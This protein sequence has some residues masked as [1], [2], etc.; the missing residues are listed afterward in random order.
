MSF[1]RTILSS[2]LFF[3]VN[4]FAGEEMSTLQ[5]FD[6]DVV[7]TRIE[8]RKF[9]KITQNLSSNNSMTAKERAQAAK[10]ADKHIAVA[11]KNWGAV[12][13]KYQ[14]SIPEQY[15]NDSMFVQKLGNIE[16]MISQMRQHAAEAHFESALKTSADACD[17]FVQ[18]HEENGLHYAID[19][20]FYLRNAVKGLMVKADSVSI[21][22]MAVLIRPLIDIRNNMTTVACPYPT[23]KEKCLCYSARIDKLSKSMDDIA[24]AITV[25]NVKNMKESIHQ[26]PSI[27]DEAYDAALNCTGYKSM[28]DDNAAS[29]IKG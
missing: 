20:L 2:A 8:M 4:A 22:S 19:K 17:Q 26:L 7:K 9:C 25:R 21:D 23:S 27:L 15:R 10:L 5:Q 29:D 13:G 18:M 6:F 28:Q 11:L 24:L 1:T 14:K 3:A 12:K 16:T